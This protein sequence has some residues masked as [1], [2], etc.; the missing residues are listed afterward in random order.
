[1]I[2]LINEPLNYDTDSGYEKDS[3]DTGRH[4]DQHVVRSA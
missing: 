4:Q 1:M 3:R 2:Y